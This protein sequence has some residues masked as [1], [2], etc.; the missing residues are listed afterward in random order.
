MAEL[1]QQTA[2]L[3]NEI[4]RLNVEY[5]NVTKENANVAAFENK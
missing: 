2:L 4:N 1:R 5:E 3:T